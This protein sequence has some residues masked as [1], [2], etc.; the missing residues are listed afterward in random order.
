MI[1]NFLFS[2]SLSIFLLLYYESLKFSYIILQQ[3]MNG[4]ILCYHFFSDGKVW[5]DLVEIYLISW[6]DI[7]SLFYHVLEIIYADYFLIINLCFN[8]ILFFIFGMSGVWRSNSPCFVY[9]LSVTFFKA[10]FM[11]T[12][13]T[14]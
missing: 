14:L 12:L 10:V 13:F 6:M 7:D 1:G 5:K 8:F 2:L 9:Y 4:R 11:T 3:P